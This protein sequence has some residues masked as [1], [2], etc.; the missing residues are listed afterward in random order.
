MSPLIEAAQRIRRQFFIRLDDHTAEVLMGASLAFLLRAVGAGLAFA[1]NVAIG[2]LLGTEGAGLYFLALSVVMIGA[3]LSKL[4]LDNTLLRFVAAGASS[5]DWN[6]VLG[7]F[8]IGIRIAAG[9]SLAAAGLVLMLAPWIADYVFG[10]PALAPS[11]RV[12][13][14]GIFSFATMTLLAESLKGLKRI[15]NSMLVSGV[16]YPGVALVLIWPLVTAF[17]V[18]GAAMAYV[19][20]TGTAAVI[21]WA[22]W[23][24]N[25]AG[26]GAATPA[27]ERATLWQS[28]R[29]LWTMSIIN[30]GI[31]PWAPLFLLGIWGT[32]EEAGIFGAATRVAMLVTFFL[33]AVNTVIAPK[34]AELHVRGEIGMLGCLARRF[35]L[36]IT[37]AA[38]PLFVLL[39]FAGDWVMGLFGPDF[40]KGGTALAILA[41]GQA[42]NT[43]TGSVGYLLMMTAHE[44][45]ISNASMLSMLLMFG[46]AVL[47]IPEHGMIGAAIASAV[48]VA[49]M[50]IYS[51][52]VIRLRL[53][54]SVFPVGRH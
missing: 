53:G 21:G 47:L 48:A 17:G 8:R 6:R 44:R 37:L 4:G 26:V 1:L 14:L 46:C 16:F 35:A 2:R 51:T 32:A 43:I 33:T 54:V 20:G 12:M 49:S 39:I 31:L 45:D 40:V 28:C 41:L 11:L 5:G 34:F 30:R 25:V 13:S 7:V 38:S 10:E 15:R 50:N 9:T 22:M 42:V 3:V 18:P 52:V 19:L 29:P 36:L 24:A 27:F 23:R